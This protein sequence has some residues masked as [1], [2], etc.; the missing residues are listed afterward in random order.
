MVST[1]VRK[2]IY[3]GVIVLLLLA[4]TVVMLGPFL[5]GFFMSFRPTNEIIA[6]PYGIRWPPYLKN[7]LYA[8]TEFGF[9]RYT[10]NSLYVTVSALLLTTL[11][12]TMAAFAFGRKRFAFP[13]R[14]PIFMIIFVSI[15]FPPQIT[16]L[17]LYLGTV[18]ISRFLAPLMP[19]TDWRFHGSRESLAMIYCSTALAFSIYILR[20]FFAQIPQ[21][22]EDA[23]R[24][25]GCGDWRLFWSVM[26]PMAKPAIM[27]TVVLNGLNFWNEFLYAVTMVTKQASRTL[28]LAI[29][30]FYG[31]AGTD[32][33]MIATGLVVSA[34]P[35]VIF[36]VILSEQFMKAMT[37]G[38]LKG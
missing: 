23:A 38:A 9:D 15:M 27:T 14:E 35:I 7:Y 24:I 12:T 30:F 19:W 20:T 26:L 25:D 21:D 3:T 32:L 36:Y 6:N 37:A 5:W 4:F 33:G 1:R 28:P 34:I 17:S 31:D 10:L 11:V 8:F 16:L 18:R 29:M 22:L 2:K 13:F